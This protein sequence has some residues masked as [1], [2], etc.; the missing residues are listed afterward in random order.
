MV[1]PEFVLILV[2]DS[3]NTYPL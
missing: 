2:T 3:K 1:V